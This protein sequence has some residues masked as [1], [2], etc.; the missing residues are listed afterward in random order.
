MTA[1]SPGFFVSLSLG[2][3]LGKQELP[4]ACFWLLET[5]AGSL[6]AMRLNRTIDLESDDRNAVDE[7]DIV[8]LTSA[9]NYLTKGWIGQAW[10][11]LEG[12]P[13]ED[14]WKDHHRW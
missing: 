8:Q 5:V 12:E 10:W 3:I 7:L 1:V 13:I 6:L 14:D 2:E 9:L 11:G 4:E